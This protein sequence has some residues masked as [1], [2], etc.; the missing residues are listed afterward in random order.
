MRMHQQNI[1]AP[2]QTVSCEPDVVASICV[3]DLEAGIA[4]DCTCLLG[5]QSYWLGSLLLSRALIEC[6][7]AM[8]I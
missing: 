5:Q 1:S 2:H 3:E 6:A 8:K 4:W 7:G